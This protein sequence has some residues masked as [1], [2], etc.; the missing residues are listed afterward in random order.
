M[1]AEHWLS[2]EQPA[3]QGEG[4]NRLIGD[5]LGGLLLKDVPDADHQG[6]R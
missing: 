1:P 5:L 6:S 2:A 3:E 4:A